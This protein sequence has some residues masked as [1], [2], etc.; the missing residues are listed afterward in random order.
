M[1]KKRNCIGGSIGYPCDSAILWFHPRSEVILKDA[2]LMKA[3]G[4]TVVRGTTWWPWVFIQGE[5]L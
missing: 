1:T 4:W 5:V 3:A 2:D